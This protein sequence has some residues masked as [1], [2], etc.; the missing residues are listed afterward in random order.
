MLQ[1]ITDRLNQHG[2][3]TLFQ[4]PWNR[5]QVVHVLDPGAYKTVQQSYRPLAVPCNRSLEGLEPHGTARLYSS[6]CEFA[7]IQRTEL[8]HEISGRRHRSAHPSITAR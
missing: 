7:V 3:A 2:Q 4:E 6:Y 5:I 1:L 8:V